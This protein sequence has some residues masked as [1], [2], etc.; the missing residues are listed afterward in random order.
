MGKLIFL[1]DAIFDIAEKNPEVRKKLL[2][3]EEKK[4]VEK[5]KRDRDLRKILRIGREAFTELNPLDYKDK[6]SCEVLV[7]LFE[8][9][10]ENPPTLTDEFSTSL[11]KLAEE[12][13][14]TAPTVKKHLK[15]LHE[16]GFIEL[17]E[18]KRKTVRWK[19]TPKSFCWVEYQREVICRFPKTPFFVMEVDDILDKMD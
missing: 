11:D 7:A 2:F 1:G 13:S 19:F 3:K 8:V 16:K 12:A 6:T 9:D 17:L 14:V 18:L 15:K 4:F 5:L 10:E